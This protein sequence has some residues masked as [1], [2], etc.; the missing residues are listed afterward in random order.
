VRTEASKN[1]A[2][3]GSLARKK[4]GRHTGVKR[5]AATGVGEN[6]M[7]T[8]EHIFLRRVAR[9][10]GEAKGLRKPEGPEKKNG[11]RHQR[12]KM[13]GDPNHEKG[14]GLVPGRRAGPKGHGK[15][16]EGKKQTL[17][18]R[19]EKTSYRKASKRGEIVRRWKGEQEER[20]ER[21]SVD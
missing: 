16:R 15:A 17:S 20:S 12:V 19:E 14:S 10:W 6:R 7:V 5:R 18:A 4:N 21:Y 11:K 9:G 2:K 8:W 13:F 3:I 1:S